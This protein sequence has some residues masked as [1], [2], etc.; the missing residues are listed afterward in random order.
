MNNK[1]KTN[2]LG[3]FILVI[4]L[5]SMGMASAL[6]LDKQPPTNLDPGDGYDDGNDGDDGFL[7]YEFFSLVLYGKHYVTRVP[8]VDNGDFSGWES[9]RFEYPVPDMWYKHG[10][11]ETITDYSFSIYFGDG[12]CDVG[13]IDGDYKDDIVD[14]PL[15]WMHINDVIYDDLVKAIED[16]D[17]KDS[18]FDKVLIKAVDVINIIAKTTSWI[19]V[20]GT[21][22]KVVS[23]AISLMVDFSRTKYNRWGEVLEKSTFTS[24][25]GWLVFT[26]QPKTHKLFFVGAETFWSNC[27][28]SYYDWDHNWNP[29]LFT[30]EDAGFIPSFLDLDDIKC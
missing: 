14:L 12:P 16:Y 20:L 27:E 25:D 3:V 6:P 21:A 17:I 24:G 19:P 4:T 29:T 26:V 13:D 30:M 18:D 10:E 9:T 5:L 22:T 1:K 11:Y 15:I 7:P 28:I 23:K 8:I 2:F